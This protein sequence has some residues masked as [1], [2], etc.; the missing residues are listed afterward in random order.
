MMV[1]ARAAAGYAGLAIFV[2]T[3][4]VLI[5]RG[6]LSKA[7]ASEVLDDAEGMLA[8]DGGASSN[9]DAIELLRADIRERIGLV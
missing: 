8:Q 4:R 9:A 6:V 2:A 1:I 3:V 7:K 5:D